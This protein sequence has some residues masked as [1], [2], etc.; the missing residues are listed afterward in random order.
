[1]T[2]T[3]RRIAVA[4]VAGCVLLFATVTAAWASV[5]SYN[6]PTYTKTNGNNTY[7]YSWTATDG[8]NGDG[9]PNY[10][11]YVRLTT[12]HNNVQEEF[13]NG[14]NGPSSANCTGSL[15]SGS[16]TKSG[17]IAFSPSTGP[18]GLAD[19][20]PADMRAAGRPRPF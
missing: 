18:A 20:H 1:M 11:Y 7:W 4:F 16:A 8:A 12:W 2:S 15:R 17:N 10:T 3:R 6:E 14:T 5:G 19:G 13:S 9:S